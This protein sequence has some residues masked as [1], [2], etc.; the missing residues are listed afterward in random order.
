ML[1][2]IFGAALA[3]SVAGHSSAVTATTPSTITKALTSSSPIS[4][5]WA[6]TGEDKVTRNE[7][8]GSRGTK[9]LV[10]S[11]WD[12]TRITLFGAKNEVVAFNLVIEAANTSASSVSVQ[13]NSLRHA[14]GTFIQSTSAAA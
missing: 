3:M 1:R 2:T 13:F 8:R 14:D 7:L 10:N 12:G 4:A 11:A 5:V 6:N 9:S